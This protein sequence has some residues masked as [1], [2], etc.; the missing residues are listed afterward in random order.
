LQDGDNTCSTHED[1]E[2]A[3]YSHFKQVFGQPGQA[4]YKLDFQAI[5]I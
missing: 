2:M 4:G 1:I 3:L 5:G